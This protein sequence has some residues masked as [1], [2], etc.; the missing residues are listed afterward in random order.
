M[1]QGKKFILTDLIRFNLSC[2]DILHADS[3]SKVQVDVKWMDFFQLEINHQIHY[4]CTHTPL[5]SEL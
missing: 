4:K 5:L 2:F 3:A 1:R